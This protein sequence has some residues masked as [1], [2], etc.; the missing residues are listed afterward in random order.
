MANRVIVR[1]GLAFAAATVWAGSAAA[2]SFFVQT[3]ATAAG[4]I[5]DN[6]ADVKTSGQSATPVALTSSNG[7]VDPQ[8]R[9]QSSSYAYASAAAGELKGYSAANAVAQPSNERSGAVAS[10]R[11]VAEYRDSFVLTSAGVASGTQG[12]MSADILIDGFLSAS[13]L[14]SARWASSANWFVQ[15]FVND[16]FAFYNQGLYAEAGSLI[17]TGDTLGLQSPSFNVVFGQVNTVS[18]R[19]ETRAGAT[20][21]IGFEGSAEERTASAISDFDSTL[22][23]QGIRSL[24]VNGRAVD[25]FSAVSADTGFDFRQGVGGGGGAV[26]PEPG[27]W[28]LMIAGFGLAGHAFR[29]R[30]TGRLAA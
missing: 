7:F 17:Q 1:V 22:T 26:V 27:T 19:L 15:I 29:R 3:E 8:G 12:L 9:S 24:T 18:M 14:G 30:R 10:G 25:D 20:N 4:Q 23:W 21:P 6:P 2:A 5:I 28:A 11:S 13:G 16:S